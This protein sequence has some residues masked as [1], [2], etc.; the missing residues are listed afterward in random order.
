MKTAPRKTSNIALAIGCWIFYENKPTTTPEGRLP[1]GVNWGEPRECVGP[2]YG[3]RES[4]LF[5]RQDMGA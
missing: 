5:S 3:S 1:S 4:L 2:S